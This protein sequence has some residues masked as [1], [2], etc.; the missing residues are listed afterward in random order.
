MAAEALQG[1]P[2]RRARAD[3]GRHPGARLQHP[4]TARPGEVALGGRGALPDGPLAAPEETRGGLSSRAD[5]QLPRRA[6][7]EPLVP[8]STRE[9]RAGLRQRPEGA[10]STPTPGADAT[11][12]AE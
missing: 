9:W 5:L 12:L 6:V 11:G 1:P 8:V 10:D 3:P 2:P 4:Q 7:R